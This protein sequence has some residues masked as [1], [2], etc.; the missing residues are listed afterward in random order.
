MYG[1]T[2]SI[3]K[4]K[5]RLKCEFLD[6]YLAILNELYFNYIILNFS[7]TELTVMHCGIVEGYTWCLWM[8]L[9]ESSPKPRG[10]PPILTILQSSPE[11]LVKRRSAGNLTQTHIGFLF[12]LKCATKK[13]LIS[14]VHDSVRVLLSLCF[15]VHHQ[16]D[17]SIN[18]RE[19]EELD[20]FHVLINTGALFR[21]AGEKC[22]KKK[23]TNLL[24]SFNAIFLLF[25]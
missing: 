2:F 9:K 18:Q 13:A 12:V 7:F 16:W 10:C 23:T 19:G 4:K 14:P 6:W 1:C 3:I 22:I 8:C 25:Q 15:C 21:T 5:K 17:V 11:E 20:T 24:L